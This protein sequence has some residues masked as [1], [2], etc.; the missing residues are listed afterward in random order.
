MHQHCAMCFRD[1]FGAR[2]KSLDRWA[3]VTVHCRYPVVQSWQ[4]SFSHSK[5]YNVTILICFWQDQ[6]MECPQCY[7]VVAATGNNSSSLPTVF[8]IN[9][10]VKVCDILKKAQSDEIACQSCAC[11]SHT[12]ATGRGEGL[13]WQLDQCLLAF[14]LR[15]W[16]Y[17][18]SCQCIIC[19]VTIGCVYLYKLIPPWLNQI[20]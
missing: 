1:N 19:L 15:D 2:R 3:W 5:Q 6:E 16:N 10:L 4:M 7:S 12:K 8:F 14:Y 11:F 17:V 20:C 18:V 13:C 9:G